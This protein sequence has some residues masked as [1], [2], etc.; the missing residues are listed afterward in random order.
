MPAVVVLRVDGDVRRR[1]RPRVQ[2]H[3]GFA[4]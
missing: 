1:T 3:P 2:T 4:R